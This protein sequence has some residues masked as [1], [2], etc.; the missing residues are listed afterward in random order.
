MCHW[1]DGF[2]IFYQIPFKMGGAMLHFAIDSSYR[3]AVTYN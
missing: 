1:F 2:S 3:A